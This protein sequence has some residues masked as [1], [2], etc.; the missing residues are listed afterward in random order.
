MHVV[1]RGNDRRPVFLSREDCVAYLELLRCASTRTACPVHAYA[2]MSNHVHLLLG[3]D[4]RQ[5]LASA[6][7]WLGSQYARYFNCRYGRTGTLWEGRY[8]AGAVADRRHFFNCLQYIDLNPVRAGIVDD[9]SEY[10]WSS[11]RHNAL[12]D[13]DPI[14]T[15]HA[16]YLGLGATDPERRSAYKALVSAC[17]DPRDVMAIRQATARGR[18]LG[19]PPPQFTPDT[20][21]GQL[22]SVLRA[23]DA[24]PGQRVLREG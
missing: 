9:P 2:L 13:A 16:E 6:M 10:R 19:A 11:Y 18:P 3:P 4:G 15:S 24:W 8:K 17:L 20:G 14:V 23:V 22:P 5:G 12:G 1:Q 7:Q 21:M